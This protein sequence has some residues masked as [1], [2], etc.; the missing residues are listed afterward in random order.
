MEY[1][2]ELLSRKSFTVD[3]RDHETKNE[4]KE[5]AAYCQENHIHSLSA[6]QLGIQKRIIYF[7]N[8]I[9]INPVIIKKKV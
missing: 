6:I 3:I 2:I 4:I 7:D 9:I 5:I 8:S 1:D